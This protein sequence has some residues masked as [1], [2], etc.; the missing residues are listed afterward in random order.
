MRGQRWFVTS[1]FDP[2]G[3]PD[4]L[5]FIIQ[6]RPLSVMS[7]IEQGTSNDEVQ[8]IHPGSSNP[9]LRHNH[10][11]SRGSDAKIEN[12]KS[13]FENPGRRPSEGLGGT[14]DASD[15]PA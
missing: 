11:R 14:A 12:R 4:Y 13:K 15:V 2:A 6:E 9:C 5:I 10:T 7:N 1:L 3:L 8:E